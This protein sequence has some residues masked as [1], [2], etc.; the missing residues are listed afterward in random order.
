[1]IA[2]MRNL[3]L[4][5]ISVLVIALFGACNFPEPGQPIGATTATETATLSQ[6]H[7]SNECGYTWANE[8][9]PELSNSFSQ[10]LQ[11]TL[12]GA[13]GFARAYGE[14]CVS[15]TGEVVRFL[16]METDFHITLKVE[17]LENEQTLGE[18][19]EKVMDVLEEFPTDETPGP[20]PGYIGFTFESPEE[21]FRLWVMRTEVEAALESGKHGEELFNALQPK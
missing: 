5:I 20:Q 8:E 16:A 13:Q 3:K 7:T 21:S 10:A 14:N 12:P 17:N 1:M 6:E 2:A 15:E 18:L 19:I 4:K 9:L 11:D